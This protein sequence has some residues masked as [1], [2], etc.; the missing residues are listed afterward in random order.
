[1]ACSFPKYLL[2]SCQWSHGGEDEVWGK[3][4]GESFN[5]RIFLVEENRVVCKPF[6]SQVYGSVMLSV[7]ILSKCSTEIFC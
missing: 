1:M 4:G 2:S 5:E 6:S 7:K 3:V